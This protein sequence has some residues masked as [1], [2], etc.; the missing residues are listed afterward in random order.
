[1]NAE[2]ALAAAAALV[3]LAFAAA[4]YERWGLS[5]ARHEAAWTIALGLFCAAAGALW[6]G[7]GIG[8]TLP[9]FRIFYLLGAVL[10]VPILALG[11]IYLLSSDH[12][13][14]SIPIS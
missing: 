13:R 7:A 9:A 3:S 12:R 8:W 11:T 2:T 5:R 1:M 4:T 14:A 6:W 10:N